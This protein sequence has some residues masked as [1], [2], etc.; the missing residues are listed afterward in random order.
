ME[1]G[2]TVF[3][4]PR[5]DVVNFSTVFPVIIIMFAVLCV[6]QFI[7]WERKFA[8]LFIAFV[9]TGIGT[10]FFLI[11]VSNTRQQILAYEL[12]DRKKIRIVQGTVENYVPSTRGL[13]QSQVNKADMK[14]S[15]LE[16]FTVSD[17][18]FSYDGVSSSTCPGYADT[19]LTG[20]QIRPSLCV[21]IH[22]IPADEALGQCFEH[23][24]IAKLEIV[25][26][27]I[28]ARGAKSMNRMPEGD[29]RK[30]SS[31]TAARAAL[32]KTEATALATPSI[33]S[34]EPTSGLM[35]FIMTG[36][37]LMFWGLALFINLLMMHDKV[38][39]KRREYDS[40]TSFSNKDVLS[41]GTGYRELY[42]EGKLL[43][44]RGIIIILTFVWMIAGFILSIVLEW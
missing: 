20:G 4:L 39:K 18:D 8:Y 13:T 6:I 24:V 28:C 9:L 44:Y 40:I 41:I 25:H 22:Y 34:R 31:G 43:L 1:P 23:N 3:E 32:N 10:I 19:W 7:T 29:H 36:A 26:G 15:Y 12:Y 2:I 27:G 35:I 5:V 17:V 16:K 38:R 21:R 42:P 11:N 14:Y 30:S 33:I 37:G